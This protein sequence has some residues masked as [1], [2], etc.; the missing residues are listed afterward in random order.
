MYTMTPKETSTA[1]FINSSHQYVC[2]H[3]Y[4]LTV[5]IKRL[6]KSPPIVARQRLG[7]NYTAARNTQATIEEFWDASFSMRSV[8][9]QEQFVI[10]SP[11][12][13]L[14]EVCII[15]LLH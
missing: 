7:R 11:Q 9:Y 8:S 1:N 15:L 2:L 6:G 13:V 4:P 3:V 12:N 5:T 10:T 14:L